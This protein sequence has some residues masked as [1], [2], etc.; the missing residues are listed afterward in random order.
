[1]EDNI[2]VE[3]RVET[4]KTTTQPSRQEFQSIDKPL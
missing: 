1:M 3:Q 4:A 2:P